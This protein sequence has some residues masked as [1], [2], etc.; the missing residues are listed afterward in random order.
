MT[1]RTLSVQ[2]GLLAT[3]LDG[4]LIPLP[5]QPQHLI[6]LELL[7]NHLFSDEIPLCFV[8]GRHLASIQQA[9]RE[10]ALPQ[11]AWI[12]GDVGTSIWKCEGLKSVPL[13]AYEAHLE[14]ITGELPVR[15]LREILQPLTT[16][17]WGLRFQKEE[18]Q[19]KFKL[20]FY[21]N[22]R[23]LTDAVHALQAELAD[24]EAPYSLIDSIDPFT[25]DG[26]LDLLPR[27]VSKA[28]ALQ[29]WSEYVELPN[30][31][32][33]FAG[34][35]GNDKAALTAGFRS[36]L[37]GNATPQLVKEVARYHRQQGWDDLFYHAR[38]SATSGVLEGYRY[39][40][41]FLR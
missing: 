11:P 16:G 22:A 5:G 12:M 35:S 38:Q 8:T 34:D 17:R 10:H 7:G 6:D 19:N 36:I 30:A 3:D 26:L 2:N 4:T 29:W 18:K 25:G 27:Q 32:I 20:S 39:F 33:L 37:V 24:C 9:M 41:E 23:E 1:I 15:R 28:Y 21:A 40:R 31:T 14:S 13:S